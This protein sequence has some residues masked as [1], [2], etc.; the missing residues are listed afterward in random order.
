MAKY[1]R[2]NPIGLDS[3]I[4]RFQNYIF[5]NLKIGG[6]A[7]SSWECFDR[8]YK[9]P[10]RGNRIAPEHFTGGKDYKEV[11]YSD[12]FSMTSFF[13]ADDSVSIDEGVNTQDVSLIVQCN[14]KELY[15]LIDHR[16]DEEI[17]NAFMLLANSYGFFD[18][19]TLTGLETSPDNV[20][21]EFYT[22]NIKLE[23]MSEKHC[24]RLNF[25][26]KYTP[27]CCTNC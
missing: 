3:V 22:N 19:F 25:S 8:V 14:L 13:V 15:P 7:V 2:T 17:R 10:R 16:A 12:K 9:N 27:D 24:F 18:E 23:D 1:Q 26:V 20:F 4:S 6:V 11:L 5:S 21:R